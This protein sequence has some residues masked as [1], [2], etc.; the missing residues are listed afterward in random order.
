MAVVA[1]STFY[2]AP[3]WNDKIQIIFF[4]FLKFWEQLIDCIRNN[5]KTIRSYNAE[6]ECCAETEKKDMVTYV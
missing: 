5:K 6:L 2:R 1:E 4:E 3:E